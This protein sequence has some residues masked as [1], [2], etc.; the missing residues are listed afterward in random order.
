MNEKLRFVSQFFI[1]VQRSNYGKSTITPKCY[2]N[3]TLKYSQN[4]T[5]LLKVVG[6]KELYNMFN[7]K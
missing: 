4:L 2:C 5:T 1:A 7:Y 3:N 6:S